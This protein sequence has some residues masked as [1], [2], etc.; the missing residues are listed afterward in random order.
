M[1]NPFTGGGMGSLLIRKA[2][3]KLN[4]YLLKSTVVAALG[5][6]FRVLTGVIAGTTMH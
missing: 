1:W 4:S 6:F 5:D 3:M 2:S